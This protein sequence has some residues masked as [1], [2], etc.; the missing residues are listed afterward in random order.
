MLLRLIKCDYDGGTKFSKQADAQV[1]SMMHSC[2]SIDCDNVNNPK[3]GKAKDKIKR[4]CS[5]GI[6]KKLFSRLTLNFD[7]SKYDNYP[8][9][10]K[11]GGEINYK[12]QFHIRLG[13]NNNPTKFSGGFGVDMNKI[14]VNYCATNHIIL[15][16]TNQ[17][18]ITLKIR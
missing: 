14:S 6:S 15:G 13:I 7:F 11:F 8:Y 4:I 17:F 2:Q 3:I 1:S 12:E 9:I 16:L 10:I 18:A 5:V